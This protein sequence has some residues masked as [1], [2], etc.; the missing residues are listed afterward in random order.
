MPI[1]KINEEA[2][3]NKNNKWTIKPLVSVGKIKFGMKR[4]DVHKSFSEKYTEFKKSKSSKN[5]TDDYGNFH[6][7]YD[8]DDKVEAVE[9]FEGIKV[10]L[11]DKTIFPINTKDIEST[12]PG[13][14]NNRNNFI[15][16]E[17]S[18][19]IKTN[20]YSAECITIGCKGYF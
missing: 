14:K 5:L 8:S 15:D 4:E 9:I 6:V 2:N 20:S 19:T 17:R 12:I 10:I 16:R 18:I 13:I 1:Y 11:N 3:L 7:Y